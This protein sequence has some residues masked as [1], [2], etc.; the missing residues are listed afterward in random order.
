MPSFALT[1]L[2]VL[3]TDNSGAPVDVVACSLMVT[4]PDGAQTVVQIGSLTHPSTGVYSYV[5]ACDKPG[6]HRVCWY[7]E[8][9]TLYRKAESVFNL[10]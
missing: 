5:Y 3:F 1:T 9:S 2:G 7:G 6:A 4:D 10:A 8:T